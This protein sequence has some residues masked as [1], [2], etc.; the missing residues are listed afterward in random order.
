MHISNEPKHAFP[1]KLTNAK[2]SWIWKIELN[3]KK[4]IDMTAKSIHSFFRKFKNIYKRMKAPTDHDGDNISLA[5]IGTP[6]LDWPFDSCPHPVKLKKFEESVKRSVEKG[7]LESQFNVWE[8][9]LVHSG[10]K[11]MNLM[12]NL[13]MRQLKNLLTLLHD[14]SSHQ[15]SRSEI[16]IKIFFLSFRCYQEDWCSLA[17]MEVHQQINTKT[18]TRI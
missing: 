12:R 7:E 8:H 17:D 3:R 2:F 9:F 6:N 14:V 1:D 10:V 4:S 16:I 13:Q 18:N 15:T 5:T 11:R